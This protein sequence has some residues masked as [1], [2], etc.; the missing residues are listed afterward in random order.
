MHTGHRKAKILLINTDL[1]SV[2]NQSSRVKF[3]SCSILN[4]TVNV[5]LHHK[6]NMYLDVIDSNFSSNSINSA[7]F[8]TSSHDEDHTRNKIVQIVQSSFYNNNIS[9]PLVLLKGTYV[10]V[11]VTKL[12]IIKNNLS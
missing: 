2:N 8:I 11:I 4:N 7:L 6:G 10:V 12:Q 5:L 3:E 9:G 1:S